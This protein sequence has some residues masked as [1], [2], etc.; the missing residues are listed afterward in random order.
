MT[1]SA[2]GVCCTC[3]LTNGTNVNGAAEAQSPTAS[4]WP[5]LLTGHLMMP[6]VNETSG[7]AAQPFRVILHGSALGTRRL[8]LLIRNL[9]SQTNLD[10]A[11]EDRSHEVLIVSERPS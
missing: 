6:V 2:A 11:V 1:S 9:E 3:S 7:A 8:D 10:I 4:R 5:I